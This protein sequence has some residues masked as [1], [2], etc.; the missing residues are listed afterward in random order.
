MLILGKLKKKN[1]QEVIYGK[2]HV[3]IQTGKHN[4][5]WVLEIK[6]KMQ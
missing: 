5:P 4:N 2:V 3:K 6:K 1:R